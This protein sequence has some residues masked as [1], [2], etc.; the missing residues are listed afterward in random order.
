MCAARI[1]D[2]HFY[3]LRTTHRW[4]HLLC[5]SLA[6]STWI[7]R[8]HQLTL[9][10][11]Q[12]IMTWS[13]CFGVYAFWANGEP[14]IQCTDKGF[15]ARALPPYMA[16]LCGKWKWSNHIRSATTHMHSPA[17]LS[18]YTLNPFGSFRIAWSFSRE[19]HWGRDAARGRHVCNE[20]KRIKGCLHIC[21]IHLSVYSYVCIVYVYNLGE[22]WRDFCD[23]ETPPHCLRCVVQFGS[24][25]LH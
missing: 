21:S 7:S 9:S 1:I 11:A 18:G 8:S 10:P 16:K 15:S 14:A 4:S 2:G 17:A 13:P 22:K 19:L 5:R 3:K 20:K 12:W 24:G 25:F 6:I 23:T